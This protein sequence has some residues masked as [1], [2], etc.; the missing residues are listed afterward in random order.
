MCEGWAFCVAQ[1]DE[2]PV[3]GGVGVGGI[4]VLPDSR[5]SDGCLLFERDSPSVAIPDVRSGDNILSWLDTTVRIF[6]VGH[7]CVHVVAVLR[8]LTV[9]HRIRRSKPSRMFSASTPSAQTGPLVAQESTIATPEPNFPA[10]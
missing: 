8:L 2:T 1:V 7:P 10:Q 6:A 9:S 4:A 5:N 3:S